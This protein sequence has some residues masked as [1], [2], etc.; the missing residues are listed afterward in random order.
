VAT[1]WLWLAGEL[2]CYADEALSLKRPEE[3]WR[4]GAQ[5]STVRGGAGRGLK[6]LGSYLLC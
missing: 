1:A 2:D 3:E 5:V 4:A 6:I